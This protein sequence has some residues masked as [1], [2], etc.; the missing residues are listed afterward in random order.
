MCFQNLKAIFFV[1]LMF[2][3]ALAQEADVSVD[4]VTRFIHIVYAVPADA[5]DAASLVCTW[6]PPDAGDWR[7]AK[8]M[9]LLSE[10][11]LELVSGEEWKE[12]IQ[13][14]IVE[15]RAAGL[16]R[17]LVFNPY[18]DAQIDGK[19]DIDLRIVLEGTNPKEL[20]RSRILADNSDVVYME[21]WTGVLQKDFVVADGSRPEGKWVYGAS[22][23]P[24]S[25]IS[26]G[27]ALYGASPSG[28]PL[29]QLS[30]MPGLKGHYAIFVCTPAS[31]G[32]KVRL[33]GDER[34]DSLASR[35]P[36]EEILWRWTRMEH[37]GVVMRQPHHYTGYT[38]GA[39]DYI[40]FVPLSGELAAKMDEPYVGVADK[41]IAGYWEPYS[42][43]FVEDIH[44]NLQHREPLLAYQQAG[45]PLVDTQL[46][47]FGMKSVYETDLTD[48]LIYSTI[49][50]PIGEVSQPKTDNVGRMQQF[51][52]T[53]STEVRYAR[54]LG[55]QWHANFGA[56][57]CYPGSPLQ[58]DFS[59]NHPEWMRG[60]ALRFEAPEVRE[61]ALSLY[62]E[63]LELGAMGVSIDFC[64]YPETIDA[65]ETCNTFLQALHAI[66]EEFGQARGVHVPV[67][68]RFPG[69][70][71]R[72]SELFDYRTWARPP[73]GS[74]PWVDYLCPSNI[75]GK[76]LDIDAAP[77][78]AAVEG[79]PC[80]V[81]PCIDGLGWGLPMPGPF[82]WRVMRLYEAGAPG[83]YIYQA[84]A[85]VMGAPM[86]QR[87]MRLLSSSS[88]IRRWWDE[89]ARLRPLRSKRISI[90]P[91][92]EL[93]GYHGWE[94]LRVWVDGI[95]LGEMET[96]LDGQLVNRM[97][98]PPYLL[99]T[100]DD[101]SDKVIP[102]GDHTL[103]I[104]VK[105]GEGW[106]E[107]EF[108]IR[109]A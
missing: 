25:A 53:V 19:V 63:S 98:G 67:L 31:C 5:P 58:G 91:P 2:G 77:Y 74:A 11:G 66:T 26:G 84:D 102:S 40:K 3:S 35:F 83:L 95:A 73:D 23:K 99:G 100:E 62:R 94:R 34:Y 27:R 15:R 8:V 90:T 60:S 46:G 101:A 51:T 38:P 39:M 76:Q 18:P 20:L 96:W 14:R 70:G 104:R 68:A 43:A 87:T 79:T 56:S 9:P 28:M 41:R 85:R 17:T 107:Q 80:Q 54:D 72:R 61:Y 52:T 106:L 69:T 29:P 49:G 103:K 42:W 45:I 37:Q 1:V 81:L 109:G 48:R 71:V 108:S 93:P 6:S 88:A 22:D 89:D 55:L 50:D 24:D 78:L 13:G 57:N 86:H 75:Q 59:K 4:P 12:W 97:P 105:D 33:T 10:T 82:L 7:P 65:V 30:F 44:E 16:R 92:S 36:A 64:R 47:R 32:M 21:D